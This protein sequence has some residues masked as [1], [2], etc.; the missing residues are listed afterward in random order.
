MARFFQQSNPQRSLQTRVTLLILLPSLAILAI[1]AIFGYSQLRERV[2]KNM[3]LLTSQTARVV[4]VAL[5][6]D[7][8]TSDFD[9]MQETLDTIADDEYI[10]TLYLLNPEG[11]VVLAPRGQPVG[12]ILNNQDPPCQPCHSL[13]PA[14][15][16][17]GI[18]VMDSAGRP[19]FRSMRPIE[20][21]LE[22][23]PCH[24]PDQ[25]VIGLLLTDIAISPFESAIARESRVSLF[26][27]IGSIIVIIILVNL[28][29]SRSVLRRIRQLAG[30]IERFGVDMRQP[31]LPK[32]PMD[33]IGTLGQA[34]ESMT[35]RIVR[36]E[37]EN[38]LLAD[39]LAKRMSER[40]EL[41]RRLIEAQEQERKRLARELHD[42]LGQGLSSVALNVEIIEDSLEA[43][44]ERARG[45][46]KR[47]KDLIAEAT[48]R[49]YDLILDLRP[50]SLDD[51]GLRAALRSLIERTLEPAGISWELQ[52]PGTDGRLSQEIE[53]TLFRILQEAITNVLKHAEAEHVTLNLCQFDGQI[54]VEIRDDGV[55]FE[56][57]AINDPSD[58]SRGL[59]LMGM[60]E[61]VDQFGGELR[62]H[63]SPGQ[64]TQ[65]T[66][67]LPLAGGLHG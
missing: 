64:G 37:E 36:R 43:D 30:A 56:P 45:M 25:P 65:I 47:I 53:T 59:G 4:E 20:N 6:R 1:A 15:R 19:I 24:D 9:G 16:P 48:E 7:M 5:R 26:W 60:R 66:I 46:L 51:I 61:R 67:D 28:A 3:S 8:L 27:W 34:F 44:P 58:G 32:S 13:P 29:I 38:K 12:R 52:V 10:E 50:S 17:M 41:L 2:L 54:R 62:V 49:M 63:S 42:D 21:L 35:D 18:A 40:D 14:D 23:N 33:E 22:C 39:A 57:S 55:G 31:S 11:E